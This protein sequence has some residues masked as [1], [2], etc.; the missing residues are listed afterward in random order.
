[1]KRA[2]LVAY[3][4]PPEAVGGAARI[5][6]MAR[7]LSQSYEVHVIC[8]PPTY[9]F[10]K[11]E[12][13]RYLVQ[14]ETLDGINITRLWTFQPSVSSPGFIQRILYYT[15][16]SIL[17]SIMLLVALRKFSFV[18]VSTPPPSLLITTFV[19]RLFRKKIILDIR[20]LWVD[21]A[22]SLGYIK[23]SNPAVKI[24]KLLEK[25][26][27]K[28]SD[29][30]L[31]NSI[32]IAEHIKSQVPERNKDK[33]KYF[34]FNVNIRVF[35]RTDADREERVIYIGN[36]GAA[37]NLQALVQA[38]PMVLQ[39][40]PNMVFQFYGGGDC[41]AEIRKLVNEL[42]IVERCKF[43]DPV[44]REQVPSI[45]SRSLLGIVPLANNSTLRY[46]IPTKTFEYMAC[47][48]PVLAYGSSTELERIVTESGAGIF[49]PSDDPKEI[50]K[51]ILA[52]LVSTNLETY[53]SKGR[54]FV[55]RATDYSFLMEV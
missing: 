34:P 35:R 43:S 39:E 26:A 31:T 11:Y 52:M 15:I 42:G 53:A 2:L 37:Q 22:S 12:K 36:F 44:P 40:F 20:D 17:C 32:F 18:L 48:L 51:A 3:N 19:C 54:K 41:E 28:K 1:M 29:L 50:G 10:S 45:L 33:I 25:Y 4:F 47:E 27:W 38:I 16:F 14:K 7:L 6:E 8:P 13:A 30:L 5:Y 9:P 55:E 24:T 49:V 23:Q 46:A 21:A